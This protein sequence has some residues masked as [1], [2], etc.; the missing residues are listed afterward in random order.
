MAKDAGQGRG[1]LFAGMRGR[2]VPLILSQ[3]EM[4]ARL[5]ISRPA[6]RRAF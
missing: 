2:L 3:A 1:T 5:G 6:R 4:A